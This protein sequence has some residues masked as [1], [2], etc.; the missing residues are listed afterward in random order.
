MINGL[1]AVMIVNAVIHAY[2]SFSLKLLSSSIKQV[3]QN[4]AA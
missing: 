1:V 2:I 3:Y 4:Y